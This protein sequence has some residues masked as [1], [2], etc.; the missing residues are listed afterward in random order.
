MRACLSENVKLTFT[1]EALKAIAGKAILRKTGARGLRSILEGVLLDT[2][3]DA[4][5]YDGVEEV[6]VNAEVIEGRAQPLLIYG[7]RKE[8][9][10]PAAAG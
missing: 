2:M 3:F 5:S 4:P 7:E 8:Q 10:Q 1:D 6:V 9:M